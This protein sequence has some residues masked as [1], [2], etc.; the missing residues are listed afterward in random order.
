MEKSGVTGTLMLRSGAVGESAVPVVATGAVN[1]SIPPKQ[2]PV[3]L[4]V[5]LQGDSPHGSHRPYSGDASRI[6]LCPPELQTPAVDDVLEGDTRRLIGR[7]LTDF[8]GL[9]TAEWMQSKAQSTMQKVVVE[10]VD[11][12]MFKFNGII[13]QLS[14]D[15]KG[16]DMAFIQDVAQSLFADGTTNWGRVATLVAF[17]AVVSRYLKNNGRACCV[18]KVAREISN[19]LLSHHRTW[20]VVHNSW[21]GF[22]EFFEKTD[23]QTTARNALLALVGLSSVMA[24]IAFL[25]R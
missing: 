21:D 17:G 1:R 18:E 7:C 22:V 25:F 10:L 13:N 15:Q 19:Y 11:K 2:R 3:G 23:P 8:T 16:D 5:M 24:G 12:H 20:L 4:K 14:L 9:S 6:L